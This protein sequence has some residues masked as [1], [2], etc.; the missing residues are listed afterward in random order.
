MNKEEKD[1]LFAMLIKMEKLTDFLEKE[2]NVLQGDAY[3]TEVVF[4]SFGA[5]TAYEMEKKINMMKDFKYKEG[6]FD[7][8]KKILE[9]LA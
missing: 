8:Y 4:N 9:L 2:M 1:A 5:E 6:M 3:L 7:A